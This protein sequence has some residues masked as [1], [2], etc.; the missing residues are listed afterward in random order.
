MG[1][2]G[3]SLSLSLSLLEHN[4]KTPVDIPRTGPT[5]SATQPCPAKVDVLTEWIRQDG[6][7]GNPRLGSLG[8]RKQKKAQKHCLCS[9][10]NSQRHVLG[11]RRGTWPE[12]ARNLRKAYLSSHQDLDTAPIKG[13]S[14]LEAILTFPTTLGRCSFF[15]CADLRFHIDR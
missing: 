4:R 14:E 10:P 6:G 2:Q 9:L 7:M 11:I 12:E 5:D 13:H 15:R 1:F 3:T 8:F